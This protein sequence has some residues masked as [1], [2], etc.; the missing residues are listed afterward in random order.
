[1]SK[2]SEVSEE[3]MLEILDLVWKDV[4]GNELAAIRRLIEE[5]GKLEK[6]MREWKGRAKEIMDE[7]DTDDSS[8]ALLEDIRDFGKGGE[9]AR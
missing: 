1:M 2:W 9:D 7:L 4:Y 3:R 8:G 6:K 5:R